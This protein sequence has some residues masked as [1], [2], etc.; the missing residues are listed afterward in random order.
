LREVVFESFVVDEYAVLYA[1]ELLKDGLEFTVAEFGCIVKLED[2]VELLICD[3]A[4]VVRVD[5]LDHLNYIL[6]LVVTH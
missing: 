6:Q 4:V 5:L 2:I 1:G 3:V